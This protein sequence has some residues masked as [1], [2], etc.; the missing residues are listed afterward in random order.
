MRP[1]KV[2]MLLKQGEGLEVEF[3]TASFDLN[4]DTFET[5]C[6]FLNRASLDYHE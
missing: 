4:K 2:E 1:E 5:I 3:K 6:G